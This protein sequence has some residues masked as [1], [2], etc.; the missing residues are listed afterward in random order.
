M[1][2]EDVVCIQKGILLTHNR[3]WNNAILSNMD[4]HRDCY[5]KWSKSERETKAVWYY[6][7]VES[8]IW[9]KWAYL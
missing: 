1:D 2:K 5:M 8:K 6:L 9:Q 3:E 7:H 4:R